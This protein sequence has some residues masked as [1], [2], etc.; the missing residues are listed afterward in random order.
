MLIK[1]DVDS[2]QFKRIQKL[3]DSGKYDDLY[4]F[5]KIAISNQIQEESSEIT[6][7]LETPSATLSEEIL[8]TSQEKQEEILKHLREFSAQETQFKPEI[9]DMIYPFYT[10]FFPV[11]VI[12]HKLASMLSSQKPWIEIRE[13]QE[14]AFIFAEKVSEKLRDFEETEQL[15]RNRKLSTGLPMPKIEFAAFKGAKKRQK[16]EKYQSSKNRFKEQ[17]VGKPKR[18]KPYFKGACFA[19]GLIAIKYD[20]DTC[21]ASLTKEGKDFALIDNPILDEHNFKRSF[22]DQEIKFIFKIIYP[23]FQAENEI[24]HKIINTLHEKNLMS[25]DI[26]EI[27]KKEGRKDFR[28]ERVSTMGKLSEL[29]IIDWK[30]TKEGKSI[31]RLNKEKLTLLN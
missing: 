7:K 20:A 22:S 16:E 21:L 5:I 19:M 18:K 30:I 28:A 25:N 1:I 24:I 26:N 12:I 17:F 27:F 29:Q 6:Q 23:K 15:P 8:E 14:E 13:I 3:I 9:E 2:D 31:Y 10:R 4:Q 11:K